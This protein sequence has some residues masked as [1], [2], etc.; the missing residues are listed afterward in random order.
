M[1]ETCETERT[2]GAE[3][4]RLHSE[5]KIHKRG[6][7]LKKEDCRGLFLPPP[8]P[9][10]WGWFCVARRVREWGPGDQGLLHP[11]PGE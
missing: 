4:K 3:R 7:D 9:R 8:P 10:F 6:R 5:K 11:A 1:E 2:K